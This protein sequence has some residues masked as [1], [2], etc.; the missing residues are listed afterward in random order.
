ML[1]LLVIYNVQVRGL[2]RFKEFFSR[3]VGVEDDG[4]VGGYTKGVS[5]TGTRNNKVIFSVILTLLYLH[6]IYNV[7]ISVGRGFKNACRYY[8]QQR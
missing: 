8:I 1:V 3:S 4:D 6:I 2:I 7:G 5:V